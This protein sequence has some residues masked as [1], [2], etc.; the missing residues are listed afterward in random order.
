VDG[1]GFSLR[2][3]ELAYLPT[4]LN[5]NHLYY[6]HVAAS[7]GS[8]AKAAERLGVTQPTVSEQIRQLEKRLGVRLFDRSTTGLRLTEH[9]RHAY[10]HTTPMFRAGERLMESISIRPLTSRGITVGVTSTVLQRVSRDLLAPLFS[11]PGE[12]AR[13]RTGPH[14]D[15]LRALRQHE[16][17]AVICECEPVGVAGEGLRVVELHRPQLVAIAA[18]TTVVRDS[19]ADTPVIQYPPGSAYRVEVEEFVRAQVLRPIAGGEC[20]DPLVMIE[21]VKRSRSVAFVPY[22]MARDAIAS[23]EVRPIAILEP[24]GAALFA[25]SHDGQVVLMAIERVI[26]YARRELVPSSLGSQPQQD[27]A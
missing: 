27:F 2:W 13:V 21:A 5:Y 8:L 20:D 23:G 1:L 7:E 17:D 10:E 19:W 4:M 9:G 6:F 11:T 22:A 3:S 14:A 18:T 16:I 26:Q 12:E 25:I 15:L 24:S